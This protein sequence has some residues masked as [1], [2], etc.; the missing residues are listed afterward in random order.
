M[1]L[2]DEIDSGLDLNGINLTNNIIQNLMAKNGT[3]FIIIS[4]NISNIEKL[5][6]NKIYLLKNKKLDLID[7]SE[8]EK[9]KT[10]GF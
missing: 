2:L 8:F 9:I 7:Y 6:P 5:K 4:H 1:A 10:K 3:S